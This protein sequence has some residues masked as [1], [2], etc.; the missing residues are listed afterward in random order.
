MATCDLV[1]NDRL[2]AIRGSLKDKVRL[3]DSNTA[4]YKMGRVSTIYS[5][6]DIKIVLP[7]LYL[8]NK[9]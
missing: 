3:D 7:L 9:Q 4:E 6:D 5:F 8:L 2:L 1:I